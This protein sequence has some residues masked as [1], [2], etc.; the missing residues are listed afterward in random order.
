MIFSP[1]SIQ[2]PSTAARV[3]HLRQN[4]CIFQHCQL[5]LL[6]QGSGCGE[7]VDPIGSFIW[8]CKISA[9]KRYSKKTLIYKYPNISGNEVKFNVTMLE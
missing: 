4:H 1:K 6:L 3:F 8:Q 7:V 2:I 5:W 9:F